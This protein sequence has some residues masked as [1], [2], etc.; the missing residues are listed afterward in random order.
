MSGQSRS[1][2]ILSFR[3]RSTPR[4]RS[5]DGKDLRLSHPLQR[6]LDP[7][8]AVAIR[9]RPRICNPTKSDPNTTSS[10]FGS[11]ILDLEIM[12]TA[13]RFV[14]DKR[15]DSAL[16]PVPPIPGI[17]LPL[18][19]GVDYRKSSLISL[20]RLLDTSIMAFTFFWSPS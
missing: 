10:A 18:G 17:P 6:P 7:P 3:T 20:A 2:S 16:N 14:L 12:A 1:L 19:L 13:A 15:L 4:P 5:V 9:D 11:E 8:G